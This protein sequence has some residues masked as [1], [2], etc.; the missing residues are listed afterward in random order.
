MDAFEIVNE[1][2]E[3]CPDSICES[4]QDVAY[5]TVEHV[6]YYSKTC[7]ME[8]AF[9]I[10][11]PADYDGVKKYPVVYFQHGIF[12]DENCIVNDEN[13]RIR[14]ITANLAADK[15]APQVIMVF[16]HMYATDNPEQKPAFDAAAVKPYDNFVNELADDLMPYVQEHYSVLTGRENTAV[17]GFSMGG[18]ESLYIGLKRPDLF[19][20]IGAIA[21]AP[22]LVP[23]QDKMMIH[24]GSLLE[25]E[26]TFAN[27]VAAPEFVLICCGTIDG[28]VG[29][30]P[31]S[32]HELFNKNGIGHLWFEINGADH[33]HL[34]V[35][36][37]LC[38]FLTHIF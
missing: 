2:S 27:A 15:K 12:G 4:R 3:F 26:V 8:R 37:G 32:Y 10:L 16:G 35:R 28:V 38:H 1:M 5:G 13:N 34:A 22:G 25:N 23:G 14:E 20:Y 33:N 19:A 9:S 31:R 11:L 24:E 36:A 17:G 6:T 21:P 18:R 30:F 29:Q 7:R